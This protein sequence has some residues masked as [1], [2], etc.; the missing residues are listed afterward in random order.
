MSKNEVNYTPWG[1]LSMENL[2]NRLFGKKEKKQETD[3]D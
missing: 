1:S 2:V 3:A